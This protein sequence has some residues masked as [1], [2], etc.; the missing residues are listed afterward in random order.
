MKRTHIA[1]LSAAIA[2]F[3]VAGSAIAKDA[4]MTAAAASPNVS[5]PVTELKWIST[6]II[7]PNGVGPLQAA[8]ALGD[9]SK[10]AHA[11]FIKMPAGFVSAVHTH[12]HDFWVAVIS[13]VAVNTAVGDKDI[14]LPPGSYW[15][16]PGGKPHV[17]KC[18]STT[19]C[20]FFVSQKEKFDYLPMTHA[21]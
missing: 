10:G 9:L 1:Y 2:A 12:T 8:P 15:F 4:E 20:I 14:S 21:H 18:I 17:T 5:L 19:E 3:I 6:G 11:T 16:Q 7:A 13:G